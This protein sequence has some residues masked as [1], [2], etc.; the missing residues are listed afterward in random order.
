MTRS[1]LNTDEQK[2]TEYIPALRAGLP[3]GIKLQSP[4][5]IQKIIL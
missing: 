5:K 3:T 4:Y 1:K 2:G